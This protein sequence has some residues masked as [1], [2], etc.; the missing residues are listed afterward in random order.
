MSG[1]TCRST[2]PVTPGP[3]MLTSVFSGPPLHPAQD[4]VAGDA[5]VLRRV[6]AN[7]HAAVVR[8]DAQLRRVN[9]GHDLHTFIS[10]AGSPVAHRP[11]AVSV[12]RAGQHAGVDVGF[13]CRGCSSDT[14]LAAGRNVTSVF[15]PERWPS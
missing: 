8:E 10:A 4:A 7:G 3:V 1:E 6:P 15:Q 14:W 9:R 12:G 5:V 2:Q 11:D 13:D